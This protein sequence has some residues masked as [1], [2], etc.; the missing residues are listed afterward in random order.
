MF[1]FN[2]NLRRYTEEEAA[3]EV[4]RLEAVRARVEIA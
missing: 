3:P 4:R 1:A 2:F